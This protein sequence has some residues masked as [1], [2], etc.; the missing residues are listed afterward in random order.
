MKISIITSVFNN[1][2]NIE[3]TINSVLSQTYPNIEYIIVDGASTDGTLEIINRYKDRVIV[4]S[5]QDNGIYDGLNKGIA[6]A[7][8]DVIGFLHSDDLY[9]DIHVIEKVAMAFLKNDV[10]SVYGDLVYVKKNDTKKVTRYW[11]S[12]EFSI[13]RLSQGWMPPHPTLY[14]KRHIY[15]QYGFFDTSFKIAGD[16][17]LMLRFLGKHLMSTFYIPSILVRMRGGGESNKNWK[18]LLVKSKEDLRA[19]KQNE[20]GNMISIFLKNVSK[21]R[22]FLK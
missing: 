11:K 22:Q 6:L 21:L 5:E 9:Q 10:D 3:E 13:L 1:E 2:I 20:L 18:S 15:E 16:Y 14:I 4:I 7:T 19:I 8:G 12:G 17:D